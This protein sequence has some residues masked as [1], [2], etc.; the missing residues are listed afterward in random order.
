MSE[1]HTPIKW[2]DKAKKELEM[3]IAQGTPI[4]VA[5]GH[6]VEKLID[7]VTVVSLS[8]PPT[9]EYLE[10]V[11]EKVF[12]SSFDLPPPPTKITEKTPAQFISEVKDYV[13]KHLLHRMP[14]ANLREKEQALETELLYK[15][16]QALET[17]LRV[18]APSDIA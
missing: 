17:V 8:Y 3:E 18:C 10:T 2:I 13:A 6:Y 4:N 5:L 12:K 7:K 15:L 14:G 16:A 9:L 1:Q 11:L